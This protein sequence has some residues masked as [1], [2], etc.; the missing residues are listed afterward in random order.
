MFVTGKQN[1]FCLMSKVI[2]E[3]YILLQSPLP[4]R[5]ILTGIL[6]TIKIYDCWKEIDVFKIW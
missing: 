1:Q 6:I 2:M 3:N 4:F 5:D